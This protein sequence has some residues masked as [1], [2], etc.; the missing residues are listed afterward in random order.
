MATAARHE[1]VFVN[2]IAGLVLVLNTC[3]LIS[4]LQFEPKHDEFVG[5]GNRKPGV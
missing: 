3:I 5:A 2:A 1:A 4:P